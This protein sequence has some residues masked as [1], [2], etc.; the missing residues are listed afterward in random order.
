M[1][2]MTEG[3]VDDSLHGNYLKKIKKYLTCTSF[4]LLEESLTSHD[5]VK[6]SMHDK[7]L[8]RHRYHK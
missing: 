3:G 8:A 7:E 1:D 5:L 4:G 6:Y 2:R